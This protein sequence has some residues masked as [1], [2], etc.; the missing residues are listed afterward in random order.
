MKKIVILGG[1]GNGTVVASIIEDCIDA[2]QQLEILGFLNDHDKEKINGYDVLGMLSNDDWKQFNDDVFFIYTINTVKVA[3]Q[4]HNLLKSL[5][6]PEDRFAT[7]IHPTATVSKTAELSFGN[8]LMPYSQ[9]GANAKI[10]NHTLMM[11]YSY[12]GHDDTV[13]EFCFISAFA[14]TGGRCIIEDGVHLGHKSSMLARLKI[15]KYSIVGLAAAVTKDVEPFH[16]VAGVPAK[17]IG[18][19]APDL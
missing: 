12:V 11:S 19:V 4:R 6:I 8:V 7:I 13:G 9:L 16:I 10:G 2:G 15:G 14:S 18:E 3:H 1:R 17:K 5:K